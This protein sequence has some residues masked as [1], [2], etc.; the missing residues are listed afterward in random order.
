MKRPRLDRIP[1]PCP[2]P[3]PG[4]QYITCSPGQWD[5]LLKAAYESGWTLLEIKQ[6]DG[7]EI[8]VK[9]FK[10]SSTAETSLSA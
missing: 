5:K 6:K 3:E 2:F 7:R 8:V 9:A 4:K 1:I 10:K